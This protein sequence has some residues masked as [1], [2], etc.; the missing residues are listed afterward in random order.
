MEILLAV[1]TSAQQVQQVA[2]PKGQVA[3][4]VEAREQLNIVSTTED[5]EVADL[6]ADFRARYP[7]INT[8]YSK[9]NSNDIY[10]H[11]VD[12]SSSSEPPGDIIW[13]SAM[14]LQVKLVNGCYAQPYVSKEI[15]DIPDW[16]VWKDEAYAIT[17]EPIVIVYNKNLVAESDVPQTRRELKSLLS[18]KPDT[19]RRKDCIL[20][21]RTEWNRLPFHYARCPDYE[22]DVGHGPRV[23]RRRYQ[24][25]FDDG[26]D[27]DRISSGEHLIA[28]NMIGSYA[29][30]RAKKDTSIGIVFPADY[31]T[32]MSRIAFIPVT[33]RHPES[34]KLFLDYLLSERGQKFLL[35]R[36]G[37]ARSPRSRREWRNTCGPQ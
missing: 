24:A 32:L 37:G 8:V 36:C 14:D 25:L 21:S 28:Y 23:R 10:D 6:L 30:E 26:N 34:A 4:A 18:R 20:R 35:A 15:A 16:A 7:G 17:A 1:P 9:I 11:I 19:Y 12:P 33:S 29:I 3:A 27:P 2:P 13:S 31:I 5:L 22:D